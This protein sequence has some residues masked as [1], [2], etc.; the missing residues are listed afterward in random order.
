VGEQT[1]RDGGR[2]GHEG[3]LLGNFGGDDQGLELAGY[4]R[5]RDSTE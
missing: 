3:L 2:G 4:R 1:D 5:C